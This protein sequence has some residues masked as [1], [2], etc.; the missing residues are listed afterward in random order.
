MWRT[1]WVAV[2]FETGRT[3]EETEMKKAVV[4]LALILA[5]SAF[6]C[7]DARADTINGTIVQVGCGWSMSMILLNN[8]S[9]NTWYVLDPSSEKQMLAI[10]M[11]AQANNKQVQAT[12]VA[13]VHASTLVALFVLP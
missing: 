5:V 4:V 12:V 8:G 1:G 6:V 13:P 2:E 3:N 10:A 7:T 9:T 11:Y